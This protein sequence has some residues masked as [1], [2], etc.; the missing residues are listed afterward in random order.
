MVC[1]I[2]NTVEY[3]NLIEQVKFSVN[4]IFNILKYKVKVLGWKVY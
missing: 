2:V 1:F 3:I 4:C